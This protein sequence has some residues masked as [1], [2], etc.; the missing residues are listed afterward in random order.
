[1]RR[2]TLLL[3]LAAATGLAGVLAVAGSVGTPT[4]P[5]GGR[6]GASGTGSARTAGAAPAPFVA[7][8]VLGPGRLV[9]LTLPVADP[10]TGQHR[11]VVEYRP[12]V[13]RPDA[14]PVLYLLHGLPGTATDLCSPALAADLD[15][16]FRGGVTPFEVACPDGSAGLPSD[17]EWADSVDGTVTLETFV[18]RQVVRAVE[19]DAPRPAGL[20]AIGGF[21]MG[22]FGAA[23]LALRHPDLYRSVVT[24]AGYFRL[25]DPDHVFGTDEATQDE[26]DP[27]QL[28]G[29]A[30]GQC[31]Y[32]AEAGADPLPLTAHAST[33]FATALRQVGATVDLRRTPGGHEPAWAARQVVDAA[34]FLARCWAGG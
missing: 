28:V 17:S 31:W 5:S 32:L 10:A 1:M 12:D 6:T 20:R 29:R 33:Q 3:G 30:R 24:L 7:Q 25:D 26:H 19:G 4:G 16:A 2:L 13:A 14:L 34:R 15:A 11:D 27:Q 9:T 18:T 22:G 23:A 8:R 21:S